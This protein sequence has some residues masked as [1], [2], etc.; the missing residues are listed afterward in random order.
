MGSE[1][2]LNDLYKLLGSSYMNIKPGSSVQSN[3]C[4]CK[5]DWNLVKV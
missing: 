1:Y 5:E 3:V 2:F 4:V